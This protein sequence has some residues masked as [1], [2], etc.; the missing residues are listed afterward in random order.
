MYGKW[1]EESRIFS[2]NSEIVNI[3]RKDVNKFEVVSSSR[4]FHKPFC[5]GFNRGDM[6]CCPA[7][8]FECLRVFWVS[9]KSILN[10][11]N[12]VGFHNPC[13]KAE[14]HHGGGM[15]TT[16]THWAWLCR[17]WGRAELSWQ[18]R[19][20]QHFHHLLSFVSGS[21]KLQEFTRFE[22]HRA[23]QAQSQSHVW[24]TAWLTAGS[25]E[26]IL[27]CREQTSLWLYLGIF[28]IKTST[29]CHVR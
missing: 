21:L 4:V 28:R 3:R 20:N 22:I 6:S 26:R 13:T 14:V 2:W 25:Q 10:P 16:Q 8:S 5:K 24:C 19:L 11:R 29:S 12:T 9:V 7:L 23:V 27:I 15:N 17:L 18:A 1:L